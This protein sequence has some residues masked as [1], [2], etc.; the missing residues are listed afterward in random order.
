MNGFQKV[1]KYCAMAFAIVLSISI[2]AG[3]IT[4]VVGM[5][6]GIFGESG[7]YDKKDRVNL[8]KQ[9]SAEEI[10]EEQIN[11]IVIDCSGEI[12][13]K[14]GT[15]LSIE[16]FDVTE[17]YEIRMK[18]GRISLK[19]YNSNFFDRLFFWFENATVEEK[20]VV[21][22]PA[23]FEPTEMEIHSGSGKVSVDGLIAEFLIIDSGSG[24]VSVTGTT[25]TE[26]E[27]DTGSGSVM[28]KDSELGRLSVD[29]GSG[30]VTMENVIAKDVEMDTGSGAVAFSGEITGNCDFDTGSGAI[31]MVLAGSEEDYR[32]EADCGSGT[33]RVNGKKLKDG[34]YG[35]NVK[36][37]LEFD[38]GSGSVSVEFTKK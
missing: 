28:V 37:T 14:Q 22:I 7:Y 34:S 31:A 13:V 25:V 6:S 4:F 38:S 17:D 16:A 20:V 26:T 1:I 33:F 32:I 12:V 2:F 21:T 36:G 19:R 23:D 35:S 15:E 5:A 3:I 29:S 30:A 11:S 9:Y 24:K 27:L 10:S 8:S 18:N